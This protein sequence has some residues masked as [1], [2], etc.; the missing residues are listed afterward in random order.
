[1]SRLLV[2]EFTAGWSEPCKAMKPT[3]EGFASQFEDS[4]DFCT[5]NVEVNE[6]QTLARE[7]KVQTL[8]T[9][10]LAKSGKVVKSVVDA[11]GAEL[12][13]SIEALKK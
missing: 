4:A 1:N 12:R 5:V 7:L 8:P 10:L 9:F 2:V 6:L 13:S 3:F 11:K